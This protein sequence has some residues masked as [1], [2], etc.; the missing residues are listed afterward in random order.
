VDDREAMDRALALARRG[1]GRVAPNPMV[2]AVLVRDGAEVAHGYH[3]EYGGPHAE[4]AMLAAGVDA[5]GATCV[6]TLEPCAHT[7]KTPPCADAL[8]AAGV[9]RVVVAGRD[10]NPEARGGLETLRAA[11]VRVDLGLGARHAAAL[12]AAFLWSTVRPERPFVAVKLATSFDG[13]LADHT[14]KSQWI[15]GP[16]SRE[17]VHWLRAGFDGIAVGGRTA[18]ADDPELTVRGPVVPRVPPARVVFTGHTVL[19]PELQMFRP[20]AGGPALAVVPDKRAHAVERILGPLGV[21]VLVADRLEDA[22]RGLADAGVRSLLVEGGGRLVGALLD[23]GLVDRVYRVTAPVWL[24]RGTPA[25]AAHAARALTDAARWTVVERTAMG[26][27]SLL[28]IDRELCLR[29]S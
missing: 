27:D 5:R 10:P 1:W 12:N 4:A 14:G 20:G 2:G 22:L 29:G 13:Y 15:S 7:G 21:R 6:V 28:V 18:Q 8:I 24:G 25:F 9:A 19:G 3:A 17:W 23:R 26:E 16:E 11:G